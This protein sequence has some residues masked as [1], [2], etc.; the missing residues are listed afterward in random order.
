MP[1]SN[2]LDNDHALIG[3]AC[4]GPSHVVRFCGLGSGAGFISLAAQEFSFGHGPQFQSIVGPILPCIVF[5]VMGLYFHGSANSI[6]LHKHNNPKQQ[7]VTNHCTHTGEKVDVSPD[8]SLPWAESRRCAVV[9]LHFRFRVKFCS[10]SA[11][12]GTAL[13]KAQFTQSYIAKKEHTMPC[14]HTQS[15]S[16]PHLFT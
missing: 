11:G 16:P 3:D 14:H 9:L 10:C 4:R 6:H 15:P 13:P 12:E 8:F 7:T 5:S 2:F 1:K